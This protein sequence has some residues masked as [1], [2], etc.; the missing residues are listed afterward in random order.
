[1]AGRNH[2]PARLGNRLMRRLL[3][4][5]ALL[6]AVQT[7]T[8]ALG[9]WLQN[10]MLLSSL[11]RKNDAAAPAADQDLD[12]DPT[13]AR[14]MPKFRSQVTPAFVRMIGISSAPHDARPCR[15]TTT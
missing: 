12:Y 5:L 4:P 8:L 13:A 1:M 6:L 14:T 10:S 11:E 7:C 9:L 2:L 3:K 15:A